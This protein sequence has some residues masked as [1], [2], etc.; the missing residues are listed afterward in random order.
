MWVLE[1]FRFRFKFLWDFGTLEFCEKLKAR[2]FNKLKFVILVNYKSL[3]YILVVF[4]IINNKY[5]S[6]G[7][8]DF[9]CLLLFLIYSIYLNI[10]GIKEFCSFVII[11]GK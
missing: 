6:M 5:Y 1:L 10:L 8:K 2:M 4:I 3:I 11:E 9:L 7:L